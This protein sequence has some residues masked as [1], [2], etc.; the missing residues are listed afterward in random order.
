MQEFNKEVVKSDMLPSKQYSVDSMTET[1]RP[2]KK[3]AAVIYVS[4]LMA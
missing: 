1:K 3:T 4:V 2:Y